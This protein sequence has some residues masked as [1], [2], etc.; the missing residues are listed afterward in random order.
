ME[1]Y[2]EYQVSHSE[3]KDDILL[4]GTPGNIWRAWTR[5]RQRRAPIGRADARPSRSSLRMSR[6]SY[7]SLGRGELASVSGL[8]QKHA[9]CGGD[10]VELEA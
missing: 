2:H 8:G 1:E 9:G 5:Q 4:R 3:E 6:H 10:K 7:L